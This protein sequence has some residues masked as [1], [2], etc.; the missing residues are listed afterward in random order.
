[1]RSRPNLNTTLIENPN[2]L[3][4]NIFQKMSTVDTSERFD[5]DPP[6]RYH[7]NP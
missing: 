1:M 3:E 2:P 4:S 6:A 7:L 5:P